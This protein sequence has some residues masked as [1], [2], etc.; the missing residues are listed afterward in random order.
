MLAMT[1]ID[2]SPFLC[3]EN[4]SILLIL[5]LVLLV[6]IIL[7]LGVKPRTR[8]LGRG[9]RIANLAHSVISFVVTSLGTVALDV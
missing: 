4:E 2:V 1:F 7:V 3:V 6:A 8:G 5:L 9:K